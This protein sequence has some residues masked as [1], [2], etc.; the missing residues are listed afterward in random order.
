MFTFPVGLFSGAVAE[1]W[2]PA[3]IT[4]ALWLEAWDE[5]T[6]YNATSGGSLVANGGTA[7]RWEDKS[8][9]NRHFTNSN[10]PTW[11]SSGLLQ[12]SGNATNFLVG[13]PGWGNQWEIITIL[14]FD[15]TDVLQIPFRDSQS[16]NSTTIHGY[17]TSSASFYR[18]RNTTSS[19]STNIA[20]EF[21]TA[22]RIA[23]MS[24][25]S[26]NN[27][28]AFVDGA[29]RTTWA[30]SGS[31]GTDLYLGTNGTVGVAGFFGS[32]EAVIILPSEAD[33]DTRQRLE[34]YLAHQRGLTANLAADHPYKTDPPTT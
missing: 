3:D 24:S 33:T 10:G 12:F 13:S 11:S 32:L 4:T 14:K 2:T 8:G 34:G 28:F 31:M 19:F 18:A 25:R 27:A 23:G 20:T 30:V 22:R 6:I 26:T 16:T 29:Q 17:S 5:S 1:P 7:R 9:N 21:G 15:R